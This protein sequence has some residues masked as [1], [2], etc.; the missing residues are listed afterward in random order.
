M[1]SLIF[2]LWTDIIRVLRWYRTGTLGKIIVAFL[3]VVL[4]GFLGL[5][6]YLGSYNFLLPLSGF[7]VY[8]QLTALYLV[9]ASLIVTIWLGTASGF[10]STYT[11]LITHDP[12][13]DL[14]LTYPVKPIITMVR[15]FI[16]GLVSSFF[17]SLIILLPLGLAVS[18]LF[19]TGSE[20]ESLFF[21]SLLVGMVVVICA[22]AGSL[23]AFIAAFFHRFLRPSYYLPLFAA[24]FILLTLLLIRSLLPAE[25]ARLYVAP[26]DVFI[27][28][29]NSL[30]LNQLS[31]PTLPLA[32][33]VFGTL[34]NSLYPIVTS[35][36]L[37]VGLVL[38]FEAKYLVYLR[39]YLAGARDVF[40]A[41]KAINP[42]L[43]MKTTSIAAK[44]VMAI[45]RTPSEVG[46]G[47]FLLLLTFGF[48]FFLGT[49]IRNVTSSQRLTDI[50][51]Y[52]LAWLLFYA[53]AYLLRLV[54]PLMAKE[55]RASWLF[56]TLPLRP[57]QILNQKI[58]AAAV[59]SIPLFLLSLI[60]WSFL[61][62][63][64]DLA[65]AALVTLLLFA[66]FSAL[67]GSL[68]PNFAEASRPERVSTSVMGLTTFGTLLGLSYLV[69][70]ETDRLSD[71]NLLWLLVIGLSF[72][73]I[74][75]SI[76]ILAVRR[77]SF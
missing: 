29:F 77:Y 8:G 24:V 25:L 57:G 37:A 4:F 27:D 58:L 26:P 50:S 67:F 10:A 22:L 28:I 12:D 60:L 20:N 64:Y 40:S 34:S 16:R 39:Q 36:T 41:P 44:D 66:I 56:F 70:N 9:H 65:P 53:I 71:T 54:F 23:L 75:K 11:F 61:G 1:T 47:L 33:L 62:V 52:A 55:G 51:Y 49:S 76:A 38:L 13:L 7:E 3:F 43:Y 14:L 30:P 48:F 74:L 69:I 42:F 6:I 17:S 72:L 18:R 35:L 32:K 68:F 21:L 46:Y 19:G 2:L 5:F 73:V 59:I 15:L 31:L 45:T 63:G